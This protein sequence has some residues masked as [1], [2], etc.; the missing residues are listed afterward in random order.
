MNLSKKK[1]LAQKRRWRI[2]KKVNGTAERPRVTVRFT[3]K[4]I[5]AQ[6]IDDLKSHTMTSLSTNMAEFKDLLPNLEGA[7]KLGSAFGLKI[8]E[9]G[10]NTIVFDRAGRKYHG[11]VKAFADAL[12]EQKLKF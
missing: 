3:N 4:N 1:E 5:H 6:C 10:V 12:R 7:N 8:K 2:R 9:E 11:C